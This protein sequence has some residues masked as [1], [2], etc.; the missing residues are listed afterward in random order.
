MRKIRSKLLCGV[1]LLVSVPVTGGPVLVLKG[2]N[3]GPFKEALSGFRQ[4]YTAGFEIEQGKSKEF[5]ARVQ[6]DHP[7]LIVAIGR[8]SAEM[9]HQR[10]SG[11]P[12]VYIMVPNPV[13]LGL[14]GSNV[15]GISMSVPGNVQLAHFKELLP[16]PKKPV[17][18]IFNPATGAPMVAE[19]QNAAAGLG[20]LLEQV[21][22]ESPEQVRLRIALVKPIIGAIWVVPDESFATKERENKWFTY[23]LSE[24][25][26]LRLPF[27]VTMNTGSTFVREGA[28]A[29]VVSDFMGMGR[30][31]GE[32]VKQIEAGKIKVESI[33]LRLPEAVGWEVNLNTAEKIGL[34]IPEAVLKSAK[35]YR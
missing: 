20:L 31:C 10:S 33:G 29:A 8:T 14:T 32:L 23:L 12:I 27:F 13:E 28:L 3:T 21:P 9:A 15:A 5:A 24:A 26:A 4:A 6:A 1:L 25:T 16:N 22:V 30:Q 2:S 18:V 35:T 11:I 17:A 7:S 34:T 19:A